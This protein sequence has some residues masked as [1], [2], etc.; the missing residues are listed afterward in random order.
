MLKGDTRALTA[1]GGQVM[2][3]MTKIFK[4]VVIILL[5]MVIYTVI[6]PAFLKP[7]G[8][9]ERRGVPGLEG[10]QTRLPPGEPIPA[11]ELFNKK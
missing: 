3:I 9:I 7:A 8:L 6:A 5:L 11:D 1:Q 2:A 10:G 4:A